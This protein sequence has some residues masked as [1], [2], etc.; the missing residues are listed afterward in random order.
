MPKNAETLLAAQK[1]IDKH[2]AFG[3]LLSQQEKE[4]LL[5]RGV[6]R[7]AA[8]GERLCVRHQLDTRIYI[9]VMGEVEV[10]EEVD[11]VHLELARLFQGE[12]FGEISALFKIPRISD[13]TARRPSVLIELPASVMERL[14][15]NR[16]ELQH[17]IAHR[18]KDR[19][20]AT[21]LRSVAIFRHLDMAELETLIANS[22][23]L[24]F[25]AGETIVHE[26][27]SGDALYILVHGAVRIS[28]D[29]N[30]IET[31]FATLQIGDYFGEWALL[32]GAPRAATVK[33]LTRVEAIRVELGLFLEFIQQ[34]PD[35]RDR[36]DQV[37]YNRHLTA[38]GTGSRR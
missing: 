35:V 1:A 22:T 5:D 19:I 2:P 28:H 14:L 10:S 29:E 38:I 36:I 3:E 6:V 33:T 34:N 25:P 32:T 7:H 16:P 15:A 26:R 13:V 21:A 30:G 20:T 9:L 8:A 31:P 11:G 23:L 37:A 4:Y 27:E 18:Y 12:V 24:G 17:A